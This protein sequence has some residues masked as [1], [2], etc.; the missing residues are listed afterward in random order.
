MV[1]LKFMRDVM[2]IAPDFIVDVNPQCTYI[3]SIR[4][5]NLNEFERISKDKKYCAIISNSY[6]SRNEDEKIEIMKRL[7]LYGVSRVIDI[8]NEIFSIIKKRLIL[9]YYS[10]Q[11][12]VH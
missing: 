12:K 2:Y 3:D 1:P 4:I 11:E 5:I 6:F 10:K 8:Y 7:S 9:F